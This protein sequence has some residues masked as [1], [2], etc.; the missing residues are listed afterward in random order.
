MRLLKHNNNSRF[1]LTEY[2]ADNDIPKYDILSHR[3]LNGK[4]FS[5]DIAREIAKYLGE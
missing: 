4:T 5:E 2:L 3:R 1:S